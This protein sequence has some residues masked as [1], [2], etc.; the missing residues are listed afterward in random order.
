M[1][2]NGT[3]GR[4]SETCE[5]VHWKELHASQFAPSFCYCCGL[6]RQLIAAHSQ[7]IKHKSAKEEPHSAFLSDSEEM[8]SCL[9]DFEHAA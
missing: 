9:W 1:C 2:L 4:T 8:L 3:S 7:S 6:A 5:K